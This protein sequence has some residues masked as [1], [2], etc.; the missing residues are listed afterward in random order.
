MEGAESAP[1][2]SRSL[3]RGP[4]GDNRDDIRAGSHPLDFSVR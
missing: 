3:Q 1:A 2:G 4:L